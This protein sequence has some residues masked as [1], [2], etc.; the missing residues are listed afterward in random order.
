MELKENLQDLRTCKLNSSLKIAADPH[1]KI[2]FYSLD[3]EIQTH[4][5]GSRAV[6]SRWELVQTPQ[7]PC[8]WT[9]NLTQNK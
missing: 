4:V 1:D 2:K 8:S 5:L 3:A 9:I 6:N 7:E